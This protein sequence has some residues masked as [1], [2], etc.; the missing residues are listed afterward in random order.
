[1]ESIKRF[2]AGCFVLL[3]LS[4]F[5]ANPDYGAFKGT[6][7]IT[8]TTPGIGAA[9]VVVVSGNLLQPASTNLTNWSNLPTN[10]LS[11]SKWTESAGTIFPTSAGAVETTNLSAWTKLIAKGAL[12]AETRSR[13]LALGTN[14]L[15]VLT[16]AFL[17]LDSPTN[18]AAQVVVQIGS[19]VSVGQ[20]LIVMNNQTNKS[21]VIYDGSVSGIG[22]LKL[23]G[24]FTSTNMSGAIHLRS[25]GNNWVE[26]GRS[27]P[28][29]LTTSA[30]I[31]P[32]DLYLPRRL[33]ATTFVDSNVRHETNSPFSQYA[34]QPGII[35]EGIFRPDVILRTSIGTGVASSDPTTFSVLQNPSFYRLPITNNSTTNRVFYLNNPTY[36]LQAADVQ[37]IL[38]EFMGGAGTITLA[39]STNMALNSSWV[40]TTLGDRLALHWDSFTGKW[41]EQWRYP[42]V[43]APPPPPEELFLNKIILVDPV[44]GSDVTGEKYNLSKPFATVQVALS[45]SPAITGDTILMSP[46]YH[47]ITNQLVFTNGVNLA[48]YGDITIVSNTYGITGGG[49]GFSLLVPTRNSL[50]QNFSGTNAVAETNI[51]QALIGCH[52]NHGAWTNVTVRRVNTYGDTDGIFI[53][54]SNPVVNVNLDDD[55]LKGA[56]DVLVVNNS[57]AGTPNH[58]VTARNCVFDVLGP[59]IYNIGS[60]NPAR[61]IVVGAGTVQL[62]NCVIKARGSAAGNTGIVMLDEGGGPGTVIANNCVIEAASPWT[63]TANTTLK[64]DTSP[65]N[66]FD[67]VVVGG[68]LVDTGALPGPDQAFRGGFTVKSNVFIGNIGPGNTD[69]YTAPV[70]YRCAVRHLWCSSTNASASSVYVQLKTNAVY[71]RISASQ[72]IGVTSALDFGPTMILEPGDTLSVSNVLQGVNVF[73]DLVIYPAAIKLYSPRIIPLATGTNTIYTVPTFTG[74]EIAWNPYA[75]SVLGVASQMLINYVNASGAGRTVRWFSVP[76]GGGVNSTNALTWTL[77]PADATHNSR[78]TPAMMSGNSVAISTDDGAAN[79]TAWITVFESINY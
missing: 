78:P 56:W 7:N 61:G 45:N 30:I 39:S 23:Q 43:G 41:S 20:D 14:T 4:A 73:A 8:L 22:V 47:V 69:I 3:G 28:D 65:T 34:N 77:S 17:L 60:T 55:N 48:G 18:D 63:V 74:K 5:A 29:G 62:I 70:G 64:T 15:S 79:Q 40:P 26:V 51:F 1:M 42:S 27:D 53:N 21:F 37:E 68:T 59:S 6:N 9:R 24:N 76:V 25:Q 2:L 75:P 13:T 12:I 11:A 49:N 72:N 52:Q 38:V 44:N 50:F 36:F 58:Q 54:N 66:W 31:N 19:A 57:G 16:N 10:A 67:G 46:G 33:N 35:A 71:Y 32:T